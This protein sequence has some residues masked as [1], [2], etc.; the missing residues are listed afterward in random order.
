MNA[1][2]S[3]DF[4]VPTGQTKSIEIQPS[5]VID[6]VG[7]MLSDSEK[8]VK[9]SLRTAN[10]NQLIDRVESIHLQ[11]RSVEWGKNYIPVNIRSQKMFLQ[12]E[13]NSANAFDSSLVIIY[14]VENPTAGQC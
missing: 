2:E 14:E 4:S 1:L 8:G 13:N 12:V 7:V 3:F 6:I 9:V 11:D 10:S 5:Q